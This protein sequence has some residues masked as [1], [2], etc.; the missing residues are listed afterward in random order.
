MDG[1][2]G[3]RVELRAIGYV[4]RDSEQENERDRSLEARIDL[5]RNFELALFYDIGRLSNMADSTVS[6]D[7][8][9]SIGTGLRYIT[10]VGPIGILYGHKLD[11][12]AGESSGRV[13]FSIGYTF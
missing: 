2:S 6:D 8:R 7:F 10:A 1:C 11:R 3:G 5:G 4:I 12:E 13:H 9:S